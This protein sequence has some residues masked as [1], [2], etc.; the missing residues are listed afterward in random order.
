MKGNDGKPKGNYHSNPILNTSEYLVEFPDGTTKELTA[1]IIAESM[2]SQI[3]R[4]R[5]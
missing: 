4:I 3:D 2:F 1:N 5:C